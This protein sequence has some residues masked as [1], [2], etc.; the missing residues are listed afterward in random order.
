MDPLPHTIPPPPHAAVT[1]IV[2]VLSAAEPV[3]P[4]NE[5][6][7]ELHLTACLAQPPAAAGEPHAPAAGELGPRCR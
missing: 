4:E 2:F 5:R 1:L 7:A 6:G 3:G